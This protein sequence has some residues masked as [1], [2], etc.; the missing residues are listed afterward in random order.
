MRSLGSW[1]GILLTSPLWYTSSKKGEDYGKEKCDYRGRY[2]D[3]R[4]MP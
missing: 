1:Q 2:L 3:F 4:D